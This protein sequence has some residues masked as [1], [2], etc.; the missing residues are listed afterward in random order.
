MAA[1][2]ARD[3]IPLL[4]AAKRGD[5]R[6]RRLSDARDDD[7]VE[8]VLEFTGDSLG[9]QQPLILYLDRDSGVVE[10]Q[11][12]PSGPGGP[13]IEE[14][15]SDYRNVSGLQIPF[16]TRVTRAGEAVATRTI[17]DFTINPPVDPERFQRP[18]S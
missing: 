18:E 7:R 2:L 10:R 5:V 13:L 14:R 1:G 8:A 12:Y 15:F 17:T 9:E 16:T 6:V 11:T 4:I 3:T